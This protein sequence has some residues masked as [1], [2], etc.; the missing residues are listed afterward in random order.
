MNACLIPAMA[1]IRY[2]R[3]F[4]NFC[5][6]FKNAKYKIFTSI[7]LPVILY[8]CVAWSRR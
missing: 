7:I 2:F 3:V 4:F 5:F 1:A 8:Q 6:L